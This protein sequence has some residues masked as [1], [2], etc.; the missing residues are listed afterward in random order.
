VAYEHI[1]RRSHRSHFPVVLWHVFSLM[2]KVGVRLT[3]FLSVPE[4]DV[5]EIGIKVQI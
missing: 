1:V 5:F 2:T 3:D 4:D